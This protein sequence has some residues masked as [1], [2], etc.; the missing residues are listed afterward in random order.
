MCNMQK[1]KKHMMFDRQLAMS[2]V[3]QVICSRSSSEGTFS[4]AG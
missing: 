4:D 1:D 3:T 2:S